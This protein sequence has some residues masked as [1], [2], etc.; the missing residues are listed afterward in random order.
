MSTDYIFR[1]YSSGDEDKISELLT[2]VFDGWPRIDSDM[3]PNEYWKWKYLENPIHHSYVTVGLDGEK[4]ISCHHLMVQK[5][6]IMDSIILGCTATDFAVHPEYQGQGISVKTS[7]PNKIMRQKDDVL[8]SYFITRNPILIKRFSNPKGLDIRQRFPKEI[9]NLTRISDIDLHFK[10]MPIDN[11]W[12]IKPG[13]KILKALNRLLNAPEYHEG[14]EIHQIESFGEDINNFLEEI[15]AGHSFMMIRSADYLNW[16]YAYPGIGEYRKYIIKERDRIIGYSVLRINRYN[17]EYPIGYIVELVTENGREDAAVR[18]VAKAV[19]Y[20][21]KNNVNIVNY[22]TVKDHPSIKAL[23]RYGFLNSRVKINLYTT[24][25]Q[26]NK[27]DELAYVNPSRIY[28]SWGDI[29]ALP[30]STRTQGSV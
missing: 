18:L 20:F 15:T 10:N 7:N 8:F 3:S 11:Q 27:L 26:G 17:P 29:D 1:S 30:V 9:I 23:A 5:L 25:E 24:R 4:V 19:E 28:F 13:V 22:L 2:L 6:K 21:D 14:L 16:R 12:I